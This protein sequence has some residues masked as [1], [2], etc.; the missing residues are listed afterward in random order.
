MMANG[1][2]EVAVSDE[3]HD[4]PELD[5]EPDEEDAGVHVVP[6]EDPPVLDVE[7]AEQA[8]ADG[9]PVPRQE[10]AQS[11]PPDF[12]DPAIALQWSEVLF[13]L[14][15]P[16]AVAVARRQWRLAKEERIPANEIGHLVSD[17]LGAVIESMLTMLANRDRARGGPKVWD[18]SLEAYVNRAI[19]NAVIRM[20]Q[21]FPAHE[22]P[23]PPVADDDGDDDG[24][25][26]G[27]ES[28][29]GEDDIEADA[30]R[31]VSLED[32]ARCVDCVRRHIL[33]AL[34]NARISRDD[35]VAALVASAAL[36]V[37]NAVFGPGAPDVDPDELISG[38]L[39]AAGHGRFRASPDDDRKTTQKKEQNRS[40]YGRRTK[41]LL[42]AAIV[43]C[44][45]DEGR[46]Q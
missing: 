24:H 42:V 2:G 32:R 29:A 45:C 4:V 27:L 17:A 28:V 19:R 38:F 23:C 13:Y 37:A 3:D 43:D 10:G 11:G 5:P 40:R 36:G 16:E 22:E 20:N 12:E 34:T 39:E 8:E 44:G 35:Q 14:Y 46:N 1:E 6:D 21:G 7:Q 15:S 41:A 26:A 18:P 25:D 30:L 31:R 33:D 9:D